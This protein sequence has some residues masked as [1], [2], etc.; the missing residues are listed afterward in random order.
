MVSDGAKWA[1]G[2]A[3]P[4]L[5]GLLANVCANIHVAMKIERPRIILICSSGL[6]LSITAYVRC[7]ENL[8]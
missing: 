1:V 5:Q 7:N 4:E 6:E 3:E 2:R 8:K